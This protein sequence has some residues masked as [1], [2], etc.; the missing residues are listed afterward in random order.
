MAL[1]PAAPRAPIHTREIVCCGHRRTDGLWDIEAR[2]RDRKGYAVHN[3]HRTVD[4]GGL[5]HDMALRVTVDDTLLIHG[6]D[7][8]I[9]AGPHRI[10]PSVTPNFQRLL[11]LR[12]EPGF[13]ADL[14]RRL[15]GVHGC[16]HLVELFGQLATTAIQSVHPLRR[17]LPGMG[18]TARPAQIDTCHALSATGEVVEKYWPRFHRRPE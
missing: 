14:R 1:P 18:G 7:A 16:T 9:D 15:G 2:M 8:C 3:D 17:S 10:C 13:G 12:I 6:I 11:G 4:A 5:F